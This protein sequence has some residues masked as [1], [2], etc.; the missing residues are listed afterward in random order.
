MSA[1]RVAIYARHST[2]KQNA[3]SSDDQATAC[4]TIVERLGGTVVGTFADPEVSGYRRDRPGLLGL[5]DEVRA[6]RVDIVVAEALDRIARD[7]EDISWLGKKLAFDR[8]RIHTAIEGEI[9][10]IK[11][12]VAGLLGSMF[13]SNLRHK[14]LRGQRAAVLAGR[15]AGG[16]AYGYDRIPAQEHE[17][18][19][20][21]LRV[22]EAEAAIV[23]RICAEFAGGRS[24]LQIATS[25]NAEGVP[26]PR[27]GQWNG[28][29]I[30]GDPSKHVGILSNPLYRGRL[31]WGRREWRKDPDSPRRERRYRMREETEWVEV[32]VPDL[33]VIDEATANAVDAEFG[34][35]ARR[36]GVT[37]NGQRARYL[38]S[39][40][41]K[42]GECGSSFT[43]AGKDYY[44][45]A[46]QRER[47][48][49]GNTASIRRGPLEEAVLSALQSRL[50]TADLAQVFAEEFARELAA[51]TRGEEAGA[52][53][54]RARFEEVGREIEALSRNLLAGVVGPTI[55]RMLAER[56]EEKAALER[57]VAATA[58]AKGAA[59]LPHPVL[60]R[61]FEEKVRD[62]RSALNDPEVRSEAAVL[63]QDLIETVTIHPGDDGAAE[64][65]VV[66]E[67]AKLVAFANG[68]GPLRSRVVA[69]RGDGPLSGDRSIAV[70]AGTRF[71]LN[72]RP[73][74]ID[75]RIS[76]AIP[77]SA[78]LP[79]LFAT[80]A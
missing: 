58:R 52:S 2:D 27:G 21:V 51:R 67:A 23:R 80:I 10:E 74:A 53:R 43:L 63:V 29:T 15:L 40:L 64:A 31:V 48:V 3:A 45:C 75:G 65:E 16:R 44:R 61:K 7:P 32:A 69:S 13:L 33:R 19:G 17:G 38:L 5:L 76:D 30:R 47:G 55:A 22:N 72:L 6:R 26:G 35:R 56:E 39:G 9:D 24:S 60:L 41:V 78:K 50:L 54:T 36:K 68:K 79:G 12:A 28:S 42:C 37:G 71:H 1:P 77:L 8:V 70:V 59:V 20:T 14:T 46:G 62:L 18:A 49:C 11:L 34:R 73:T 4:L 25:L 66:A 57:E